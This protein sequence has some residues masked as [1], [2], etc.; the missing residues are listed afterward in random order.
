M[1]RMITNGLLALIPVTA[2]AA[3]SS[4]S[5]NADQMGAISMAVTNA[6]AA[7][8]AGVV[9][10]YLD[11]TSDGAPYIT[12][13][14]LRLSGEGKIDFNGRF[15]ANHS[16]EFRVRVTDSADRQ[17][18][19]GISDSIYVADTTTQ[20]HATI[21]ILLSTALGDIDGI[22][23][24]DQTLV[25]DYVFLTPDEFGPSGATLI[26]CPKAGITI[27][28]YDPLTITGGTLNVFTPSSFAVQPGCMSWDLQADAA[29]TSAAPL[30]VTI[31]GKFNDGTADGSFSVTKAAAF[32]PSV[33]T[34]SSCALTP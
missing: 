27:A 34:P 29:M 9:N 24:F 5:G 17:L 8:D 6:Q 23:Q 26:A 11:V 1:R 12:N 2:L 31:T 22:V 19:E 15:P 14:K 3:C 13:Q 28:Q 25:F 30:T 21:M 33:T 20:Y 4:R 10:A 32:D 16:Y 18:G 7:H